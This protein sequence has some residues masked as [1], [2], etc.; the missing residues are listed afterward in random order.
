MRRRAT[1]LPNSQFL[2]QLCDAIISKL[3]QRAE[4]QLPSKQRFAGSNPARDARI[5]T[6]CSHF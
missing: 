1:A 5:A 6:I 4:E 2:D 3:A